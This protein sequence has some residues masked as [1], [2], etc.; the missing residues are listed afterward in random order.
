MEELSAGYYSSSI[1]ILKVTYSAKGLTSI[2]FTNTWYS[3]SRDDLF[4][5]SCFEQLDAYFNGTLQEFDLKLDLQGTPFQ[6]RVW[7]Q[8]QTIPYGQTVSYQHIAK[9]IGNPNSS[10]AV[11]SAN[12]NNPVSII[13]PCHRVIGS[14]GNLTG[15]A[16]GIWRKKWLLEHEQRYKQM[17]IF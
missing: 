12:G 15:Y 10:R 7:K 14:T 16:G 11:G 17:S 2:V 1:G 13:V 8:L 9:Q 3:H 4:L 6:L 5:Q